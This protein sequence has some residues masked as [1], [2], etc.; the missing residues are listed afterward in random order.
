MIKGCNIWVVIVILIL[1]LTD[2]LN[3]NLC[4]ASNYKSSSDRA[5]DKVEAPSDSKPKNPVVIKW[6]MFKNE[7]FHYSFDYPEDWGIKSA[8]NNDGGA[9]L[10]GDSRRNLRVYASNIIEGIKNPL[11]QGEHL[12]LTQED[13]E[14]DSIIEG[15]VI[16]G[17]LDKHHYY[18]IVVTYN[19][20]AYHLSHIRRRI[21]MRN[22]V[23]KV[24]F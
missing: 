18:E 1:S 21:I 17:E 16:S 14:L 6:I 15:T 4:E 3:N 7:R 23:F 20:I 19:N 13:V 8:E 22:I 2:C 9:F 24:F 12:S 11:T 5:E 10:T